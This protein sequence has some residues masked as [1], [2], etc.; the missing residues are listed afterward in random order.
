MQKR[1]FEYF[2][3]ILVFVLIIMFIILTKPPTVGRVIESLE[4][5]ETALEITIFSPQAGLYTKDLVMLN[6]SLNKMPTYSNVYLDS[7]LFSVNNGTKILASVSGLPEGAHEIIISAILNN[8]ETN[9][10]VLFSVDTKEPKITSTSPENNSQIWPSSITFSVNYTELNLNETR[11]FWKLND[12]F[13]NISF[14]CTSGTSQSC[15]YVLDLSSATIGSAL[16]YYFVLADSLGKV[17]ESSLNSLGVIQCTQNWVLGEWQ[18]CQYGDIQYKYWTD[19][20]NC[21]NETGKPEKIN[22]TCNY[23]T[24]N[25]E[26]SA[27]GNCSSGQQT[28]TCTN[29]NSCN[30]DEPAE[31]QTCTEETTT[32]TQKTVSEMKDQQTQTKKPSPTPTPKISPTPTATP[33]SQAEAQEKNE[34]TQEQKSKRAGIIGATIGAVKGLKYILIVIGALVIAY[35]AFFFIRKSKKKSG[36]FKNKIMKK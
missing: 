30:E 20:S 3:V 14:T 21:N 7:V 25:W 31:T 4:G 16:Y 1:R 33:T 8:T 32:Q 2:F 27:W 18:E 13:E 17:S 11:L 29:S 9:K 28:R 34:T 12:G 10:S 36:R 15:S 26:C 35:L 6:A 24:P 22:Q 5:N 23:C 19:T